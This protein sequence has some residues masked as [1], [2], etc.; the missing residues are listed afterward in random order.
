MLAYVRDNIILAIHDDLQDVDPSL[1]GDNVII[2][3]FPEGTVFEPVGDPPPIDQPDL[4]PKMV[5]DPTQSTLTDYA[6]NMRWRIENGGTVSGGNEFATDAT[7]IAK[8][9]NAN[10]LVQQTPSIT[11]NWKCLDGT[12][13]TLNKQQIQQA[14]VDIANH[15]EAAFAA[16]KN[17]G[18]AI[19]AGTATTYDQV[20]AFFASVT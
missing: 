13:V 5:P 7:G 11:F 15:V 2:I 16:E 18:A 10:L 14:M 8:I 17:A 1:Y 9:N 12:W 6:A 4:R 20:A 19:T 3:P